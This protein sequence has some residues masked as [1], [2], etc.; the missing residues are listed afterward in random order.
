MKYI[1]TEGKTDALLI[2]NI[3]KT[4]ISENGW[5]VSPI[6]G[7]QSE[8]ISL[9]ISLAYR[10]R[11]GGRILLI[12]DFG[13]EMDDGNVNVKRIESRL[14]DY[15]NI[16]IVFSVPEIEAE[17]VKICDLEKIMPELSKW[18]PIIPKKSIRKK[19]IEVLR[20]E[21]FRPIKTPFY[22]SIKKLLER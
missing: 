1:I 4:E 21:D 22:L 14:S 11:K 12:I 18:S 2:S 5:V 6:G 16:D 20:N 17:I 8:A 15:E 19:A 13:G 9:A 7:G 3:F 10:F